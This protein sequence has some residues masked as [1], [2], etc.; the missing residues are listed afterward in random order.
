[1]IRWLNVKQPEPER[2]FQSD[3]LERFTFLRLRTVWA[4]W[5]P[6][7]LCLLSASFYTSGR[8][9]GASGLAGFWPMVFVTTLIVVFGL[10]RWSL[11]EYVLHRY[12]FHYKGT[13]ELYRKIAWYS[14]GIHHYQAVLNGR[15]VAP[16]PFSL[17]VGALVGFFDWLILGV[18]FQV[19]WAGLALFAG[20]VFGYLL[21][22]T[23]HW[24]VHFIDADWSWYR[25]LRSH[26]MRHHRFP[27][28]RFGV[29]NTFWD[30]VFQTYPQD[31]KT[32]ESGAVKAEESASATWSA[33][34]A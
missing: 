25:K 31:K 18:I 32:E 17:S 7:G 15:L 10:V 6:I 28:G 19:G 12:P 23:I 1:M 33:G 4:M 22:D 24:S 27:D 34:K 21:Y 11:I 3:F 26:H 2:Y 8:T 30:H 29:S 5:L 20:T 13:N 14:H 16:L 9:L